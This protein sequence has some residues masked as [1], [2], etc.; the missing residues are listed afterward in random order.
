[1]AGSDLS[2]STS[3]NEDAR[4]ERLDD[5]KRRQRTRAC[6]NCRNSK[7][8]CISIAGQSSCQACQRGSRE[9]VM[10][11]PA[12]QRTRTAYRVSELEKKIELLTDALLARNDHNTPAT[13]AS[14]STR[15]IAD[16]RAENESSHVGES[17]NQPQLPDLS[18]LSPNALRHSSRLDLIDR[19]VIQL[20]TANILLDHWKQKMAI[21]LPITNLSATL[22]AQ[23]M[24]NS[25]PMVFLAVLVVAS[26]SI[27]PALLPALLLELNLQIAERVLITGEKSIDLVQALLVYTTHFVVPA[28][29]TRTSYNQYVHSAIAVSLDLGL[30]KNSRPRQ[31]ANEA[32]DNKRIWSAC[33]IIA[34]R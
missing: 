9:C 7:I 15:E 23:D 20:N 34:S 22:T 6:L 28:R 18:I 17:L 4:V 25:K 19:G 26:A 2:N 8:K 3:E 29:A 31:P 13:T 30:D 32:D 10:P 16:R 1:M 5:Q 12:R 11:G 24:R 27:K 33:Y 21:F 14:G